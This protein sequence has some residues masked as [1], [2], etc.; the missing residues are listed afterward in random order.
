MADT[1]HLSSRQLGVAI[2]VKRIEDAGGDALAVW[3]SQTGLSGTDLNALLASGLLV[4]SPD[5]GLPRQGERAWALVANPCV[6]REVWEGLAVLK[7]L[8]EAE[9]REA[10]KPSALSATVMKLLMEAVSNDLDELSGT[11]VDTNT[12]FKAAAKALSAMH[13]QL[14]KMEKS[15]G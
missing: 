13:L 12:K 10:R 9:E 2:E 7:T 14:G 5:G 8:K 6:S 15:D 3:V 11:V 1:A 4:Q